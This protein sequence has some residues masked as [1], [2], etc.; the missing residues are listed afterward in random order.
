MFIDFLLTAFEGRPDAEAIVW[1]DRPYTC[2]WL[3]EQ[4][5]AWRR[6][7]ES[8][9]IPPGSVVV[10]EGDF[11]PSA[12]CAFFALV[13]NQCII[14]PLTKAVAVKKDEFLETAEVEFVISID[15]SGEAKFYRRDVRAAHALYAELRARQHPGL[16]L[17]SSGSTGKAKAAVHDLVPIL[18]KFHAPGRPRRAIAFLLFDHI[19]GLNT[20]LHLLASG[21]CM[22]T[23]ED[24]SP[25][26]VLAA[27]EE[28]RVDL[29][30]TSPTFINLI[31]LS[32]AYN[33]H[34]LSSL[35]LI[36]YGTEP[37]PESTLQRFHQLFPR[38]DLLQTYGLSEVGILRSKSKTSDSLWVKLGGEGFDIRVVDGILQ[39]KSRSVMLGYLNAPSPF[40]EDG[41][42][43]TGD[44]VEQEGEYFR[45]LGRQSEIINVGGEKVYPAEVEDVIGQMENVAEA[46]VYGERNPIT[47]NIVCAKVALKEPE[48]L[49][50]FSLRL[51]RYCRERLQPFQVPVRIQLMDRAG[52]TERFKKRRLV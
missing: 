30:P 13:E 22:V 8:E 19:G 34:D 15:D 31:L 10:L 38:I 11:S 12:I 17:F 3:L 2:R 27:V 1:R 18:E 33:R 28:H 29:L 39:I 32:E 45:I 52:Y 46:V 16:V 37:M 21:G 51:K 50:S 35:R 47:G 9:S 48:D 42:F 6:R 20:M 14:V 41:W 24:R 26:S 49:K 36:S 44:A 25:D 7:I 23:V 43:V 4:T 40:T 5:D